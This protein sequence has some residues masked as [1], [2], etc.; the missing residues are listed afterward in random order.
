MDGLTAEKMAAMYLQQVVATFGLPHEIMSDCDHVINSRFMNTLCALSGVTQH[1]SIIYRPRGN[2]RAETAVRLVVDMLRRALV[3]MP[4]EWPQALPWALW[5]LNELP[6]VDGAHSPHTLVFGREPIGL[7]DAPG[8]RIG[9]SSDLAEQWFQKIQKLRQE[10]QQRIKDLHARLTRRFQKTHSCAEYQRGDRVWVRNL[11]QDGNK[12]DPLWTGP[13]E[14]L[15]RIGNRGRYQFAVQDNIVDVHAD[16]LKM[17][18]PQVDGTKI[19]LNYYRPHRQV[20]ED[21]SY[22]VEKIL[23]HRIRH[24][25]RQWKLQWQGYDDDFDTWEPASSFVGHL[26]QDWMDYNRQHHIEV[27]LTTVSK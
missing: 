14:I 22:V 21:D 17:Y 23:A 12:L 5:Q 26:Q 10:V 11:P 20:P 19:I 27:P 4:T 24:G 15:D 6:G 16:R 18:L 25:Q 3:E 9:R 1:T 13:C 8:Y 2:G 7:G